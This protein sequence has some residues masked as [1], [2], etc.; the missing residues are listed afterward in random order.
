MKKS[1]CGLFHD[2]LGEI[3]GYFQPTTCPTVKKID[4]HT[5]AYYSR[6]YENYGLN[7]QAACNANL[8]Y[9]S[10]VL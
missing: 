4:G 6:Y 3:D 2:Y 8:R 7:C 9:Q 1:H 10:L 5:V